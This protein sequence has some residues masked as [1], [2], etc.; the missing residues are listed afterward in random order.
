MGANGL[1]MLFTPK[2]V[3]VI[4]GQQKSCADFCGYHSNVGAIAYAIVPYP[5]QAC[6]D[7][8]PTGQVLDALTCT[9]SHEICESITDPFDDGWFVDNTDPAKQYEV[10]DLCAIPQWQTNTIDG[11]V[12]Q[13]EWSNKNSRCV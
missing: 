13:R 11:Y 4:S 12:V 5:C 2:G 10:G 7:G 6:I 8:V 3:D 1:W 9:L